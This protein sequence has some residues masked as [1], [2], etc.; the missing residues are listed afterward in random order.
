ME[1]TSYDPGIAGSIVF[2]SLTIAVILLLISFH[3]RY[4]R[5]QQKRDDQ[6][7]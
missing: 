5:M 3:R 4:K 1:E 7:N 2:S 6:S